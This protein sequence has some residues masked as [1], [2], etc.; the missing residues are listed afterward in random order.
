MTSYIYPTTAERTEQ[1]D[2]SRFLIEKKWTIYDYTLV[3]S[4]YVHAERGIGKPE[5]IVREAHRDLPEIVDAAPY[6]SDLP[7]FGVNWAAMGVRSVAE[8]REYSDL[9]DNAARAAERF[10]LIAEYAE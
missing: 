6:G 3:R 10:T 8:A 2:D 4:Q 7:K 9:I 5:W 1:I